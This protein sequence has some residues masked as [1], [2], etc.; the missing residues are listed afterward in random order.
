MGS[1]PDKDNRRAPHKACARIGGKAGSWDRGPGQ[2][3]VNTSIQIPPASNG[4]VRVDLGDYRNGDVRSQDAKIG[5]R[6]SI[7]GRAEDRAMIDD[8]GV[9]IATGSSQNHTAAH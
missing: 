4:N 3:V 8:D 9:I 1:Y 2:T 7:V 5:P 6:F